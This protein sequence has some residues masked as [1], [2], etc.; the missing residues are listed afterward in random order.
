MSCHPMKI[1][2]FVLAA[3]TLFAVACGSDSDDVATLEEAVGTVE[4]DATV[5]AANAPV[6]DEA[7]VM[8][9]TQCMRDR[10][11]EYKDPVV[12]SK[13]NVQRPHT[14]PQGGTVASRKCGLDPLHVARVARTGHPQEEAEHAVAERRS[15]DGWIRLPSGCLRGRGEERFGRRVQRGDASRRVHRDHGRGG[16]LQ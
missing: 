4:V 11:I 1:I 8:A 10:D 13:G 5:D 2:L 7:A 15:E 16:G 14:R 12:D 3:A 6:D 9:F